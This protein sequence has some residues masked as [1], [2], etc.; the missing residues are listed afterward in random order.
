VRIALAQWC[1]VPGDVGAN[2][3]V[4]R[5][6]I[7]QSAAQ[8]ADL[9][10]FPGLFLSG[11]AAAP[12]PSAPRTPAWQRSRRRDAASQRCWACAKPSTSS[13]L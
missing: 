11:Y 8:D 2:V 7:A 5:R 13:A 12:P 10:V 1:P 6:A 4:A 9:V 3:A